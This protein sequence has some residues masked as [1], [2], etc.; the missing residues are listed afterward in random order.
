M[1][2]I[3]III[4][5]III[6]IIIRPSGS[7]TIEYDEFVKIF[8]AKL[9]IDPEQELKEVFSIFDQNADGFIS[10]RELMEM[11]HKLGENITEVQLCSFICKCRLQ[12]MPYVLDNH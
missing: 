6:V 11:L 5:I 10:P 3:I 2:I 7:G 12:C 8:S 9:A 4:I 1:F